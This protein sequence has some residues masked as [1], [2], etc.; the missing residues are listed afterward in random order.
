MPVVC[1]LCQ[2]SFDKIITSTHLKS[3]AISSHDYREKYG[4]ES[5]SCPIYRAQRSQE[6]SGSNNKMFGKAQS[7]SVKQRISLANRG[8][9]AWNKGQKVTD[10]QQLD[11]IRTAIKLREERYHKNNNHP[12]KGSTLTNETKNKISESVKKYADE[13]SNGLVSRAQKALETKRQKGYDFGSA[14]RGK[15]LSAK[16][17]LI[18]S[19]KSKIVANVKRQNAIEKYKSR[20]ESAGLVVNS[21]VDNRVNLTCSK[22]I[23]NFTFTSQYFT[24]SKFRFDMCPICRLAPTK[25]S[26][27]LAILE[28]I[29]SI[30]S[31]NVLSG[32]RSEIYPLELDIYLPELQLAIE[33]CGLYWHSEK[34]GK[35]STYHINKHKRCLDLKIRLITIFEDEWLHKSDIVKSRL[36]YIL[37]QHTK[38]IGARKLNLKQINNKIA[39]QFC[40]ENHIQGRGQAKISYGLFDK[41]QI[42]VSVMTFSKPSISKGIRLSQDNVWEMNRFCSLKNLIVSGGASKLFKAFIHQ[43]QPNQIITYSDNRWNTGS[44]YQSL[45]FTEISHT[46]PNY[47]YIDFANYYRIHRFSLRKNK[48]DDP[49]LT[50]WQNR[51]NQGYDRIWDCGNKKWEWNKNSAPI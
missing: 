39:H 29:K 9:Q 7:D 16:S 1:Q 31:G 11:K 37:K 45:G 49:T 33:Y 6:R 32:N 48:Q 15:K 5:L 50:E 28:F 34:Q 12:R 41:D 3:H 42:L 44:I 47:W 21:I 46:P 38:S 26:D 30:Y 19:Q 14:M 43:H 18:I 4:K 35:D 2:K 8:K 10:V 13:N 51:L 23:S 22:C 25:S 36:C 17:R 24:D 20:A 27:E 40:D